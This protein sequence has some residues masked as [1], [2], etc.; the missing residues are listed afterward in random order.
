MDEFLKWTIETIRNDKGIN[1]WLEERK[2]EW[3]PLVSNC[4][5]YLLSGTSIILVTDTDRE[6]FGKYII[7]SI[8]RP[9]RL[10]PIVP[11]YLIKS[12]YPN[13][14][15]VKNREDVEH[16]FDML[17]LSFSNNYI[18]WYIGKGDDRRA[19]I[20]KRRDD[21]FLWVLDEE[22]QNS[23]FLESFDE[24][25]DI[26]LLEMFRLFDKSLSATI[27]GEI[28]LKAKKE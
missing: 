3:V 10:R 20:A 23:F 5:N 9:K 19:T 24:L 21:S 6:W 28:D 11:I 17:N 4:L 25:L 26:K 16:L 18:F 22:M 8:N 12:I 1:S 15:S 27:F 2:F 7:N 13:L 14:D